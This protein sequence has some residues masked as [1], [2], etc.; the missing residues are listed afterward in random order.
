MSSKRKRESRTLRTANDLIKKYIEEDETPPEIEEAIQEQTRQIFAQPPGAQDALDRAVVG[1]DPDA[2]PND[3][4][5]AVGGDTPTPD[6]DV[7]DELGEAVG[8]T[9]EDAEPL[10]MEEKLEK[11]DRNRWELNPVSAEDFQLRQ[12]VEAGQTLERKPGRRPRRR[13]A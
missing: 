5:E 12:T 8:V 9:Y 13:R 2:D 10:E 7:V 1:G 3:I 4:E 6:Q 11:R